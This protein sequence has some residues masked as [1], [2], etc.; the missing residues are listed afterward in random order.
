MPTAVLST[1]ILWHRHGGIK[2]EQLVKKCQWLVD[3]LKHRDQNT[4]MVD[5][6]NKKSIQKS[7]SYLK[8]FLNIKNDF[9]EIN[10]TNK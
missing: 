4:I 3:E 7:L 8:D 2:Y 6:M 10:L 9:L 5:Q 1:I